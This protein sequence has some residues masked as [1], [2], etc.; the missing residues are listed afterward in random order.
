M[1]QR[2]ISGGAVVLIRLYVGLIF[3]GEGVLKFLRPDALGAGRFEKARIPAAAFFANLDG[4]FEILCGILILL[5]LMTR[6]ATVPMIVDMVG[7]LTI[8]KVPL[9][10]GDATLYPKEG[11]F[12]DFFHEGRLEVAMLCGSLFLLLV[13][14]GT[15]SLDSRMNRAD[16]SKRVSGVR[17]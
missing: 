13:G 9:L 2:D 11:G 7:A 14:A 5:G 6:L 3:A 1:S 8:T 15:Y 12:W 4:T 10:W 16:A 17:V